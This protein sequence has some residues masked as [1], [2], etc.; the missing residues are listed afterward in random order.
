LQ[1]GYR[2][3]TADERIRPVQLDRHGWLA[4]AVRLLVA[5]VLEPQLARSRTPSPKA[6]RC[7]C[8]VATMPAR[9]HLIPSSLDNVGQAALSRVD[10][11]STAD[12][13]GD[14]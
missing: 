2:P 8:C 12:A 5:I 10:R 11:C 6:P 9:Q 7:R 13:G 4:A 1:N 14:E 3:D